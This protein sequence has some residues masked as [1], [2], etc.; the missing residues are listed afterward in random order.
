MAFIEWWLS[1][2]PFFKVIMHFTK[3]RNYVF[4]LIIKNYIFDWKWK[5]IS[6]TMI[7]D[8]LFFN[9]LL[10]SFSMLSL[11]SLVF[12]LFMFFQEF[13]LSLVESLYFLVK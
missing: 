10:K 11:Y 12:V 3:K 13:S 7:Q 1:I 2:D 8:T 9:A 6:I 4:F 5:N